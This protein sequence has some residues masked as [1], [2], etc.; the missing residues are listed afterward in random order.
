MENSNHSYLLL[1][2]YKALGTLFWVECFGIQPAQEMCDEVTE[3]CIHVLEDFE[4]RFSRFKEWSVL[5]RINKGEL[6]GFDDDLYQMVSF[7]E[8]LGRASKGV[9]SLYI[10]NSLG[11]KGYGKRVRYVTS[12]EKNELV[13][14]DGRMLLRGEEALDLGGVGK[15]Y[16][17]DLLSKYLVSKGLRFHLVNGGG[18]MYGTS[19]EKGSPIRVYL[20]HPVSKEE[21]LGFIHIKNQGFAASSSFKRLWLKNGKEVNHFISGSDE[22]WG[23]I[24]TVADSCLVADSLATALL[25]TKDVETRKSLESQYNLTYFLIV[26][27]FS[28]V[29]IRFPRVQEA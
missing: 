24:F 13:S 23:A 15:G 6:V 20:E 7:G 29:S 3:G 21:V 17:V 26:N 2:G 4:A 16:V 14:Q 28:E 10:A 8:A 5:S 12:D 19:D 22:V 9:F 1:D 25:L 11:E 27:D 18:D